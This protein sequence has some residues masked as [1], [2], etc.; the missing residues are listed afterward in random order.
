MYFI[1]TP[2]E[3]KEN[4]IWLEYYNDLTEIDQR[5]INTIINKDFDFT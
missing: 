4:N 1:K 2:N 5:L 3:D